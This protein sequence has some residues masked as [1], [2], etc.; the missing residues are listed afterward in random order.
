MINRLAPGMRGTISKR[1]TL[2][3]INNIIIRGAVMMRMTVRIG[4]I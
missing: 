2:I 4:Q 1:M 3:K